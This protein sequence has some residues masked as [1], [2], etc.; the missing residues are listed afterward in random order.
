MA[1]LLR[2]NQE[3]RW[4]IVWIWCVELPPQISNEGEMVRF[5]P[6]VGLTGVA[7]E[8]VTQYNRAKVNS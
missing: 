1:Q 2:A 8:V 7:A 6:R 5:N 4:V 3:S